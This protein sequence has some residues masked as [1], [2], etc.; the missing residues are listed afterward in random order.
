MGKFTNSPMTFTSGEA[1]AVALR[2]KL[3]TRIAWLAT[4]TDYGIGTSIEGVAISKDLAIRNYE[5]G[6]S[7]KMTA[8]GVIVAGAKAYA[9]AGGK[10]A[11]TGTLLIGTALDAA[12]GDGSVIEVM[13]H[14]GIQQSSSSSSSS[15]SSA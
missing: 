2:V 9:A 1:I 14:L 4:A 7:H 12:T 10:I 8:S 5:H 11:A 15:S 13:P 3:A 6:G